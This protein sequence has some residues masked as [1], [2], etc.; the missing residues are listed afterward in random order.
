MKPEQAFQQALA[1][2]K[3]FTKESLLGG[4]AIAGK[5]VKISSIAPIDGGNRITFSYV[6][7]DG[8]AKH[9]ALDVMNGKDGQDGKDG[10]PGSKGKNGI[11]I[12]SMEKISTVGLVDTYRITFS[13]G[14]YFDYEVK[15]G[16][17]GI[18]GIQG[19]P[20]IQGKDG[21]PGQQGIQ[22][23]QGER[24]KDGYPFL[25]YR[26]YSDISEFNEND[27]P[28]IGLMF[29]VKSEIDGGF[30]VY[31]YTGDADEAYSYI[32]SLSSGEAIKGDKGD[33]GK[34]GEQGIPGKDGKDGTTYIPKIGSV[35]TI[36]YG[37]PATATVNVDEEKKEAV[38]DFSIPAGKDG[39]SVVEVDDRLSPMSENPVQNKVITDALREKGDTLFYDEDTSELHLKS[40]NTILSTVIIE[41]GSG[42]G[43]FKLAKPENISLQNAD[44][45][46]IIEWTDPPDLVIN[47]ATQ[48][49]WAGTLIVRK[50][51][52]APGSRTDGVVVLDSK[53][54]DAHKINGFTD[55]NLTNGVE[56]FYGV[57][58]YT[59]DSVYTYGATQSITPTAIYP[60]AP[61]N[62]S[63]LG[64]NEIIKVGFSLP[65]NAI[66]AKIAYSVQQPES[67]VEP[68][69]TVV[70][71]VSSPYT[72]VGVENDTEYYVTVYS[73]NTKGR[74]TAGNMF[75]VM[76]DQTYLFGFIIN[77]N[78]S[79]PDSTITYI[80]DNADFTP[81]HM[82][83]D[84]D[85]FE[86]GSWT[87]E[88]GAWFM[89][90]KP[91]MLNYDGTVAYYLDP[92]DYTKKLDGTPSDIAN[93]DFF[94]N[95]M[96]GI[97][98]VY[99]KI[100]DNGDNTANIYICNK[101][102]DD[103]FVCW[104][105]IDNNGN[106]IDYCYM[107]CYT[108]ATV[109]KVLRSLSGYAP[110]GS[111]SAYE[112]VKQAKANN[113]DTHTIWNNE[114]FSDRILINLLLMLIGK[115]TDTQTVF[116]AGNCDHST[117]L[118]TKS[119]TM[120]QKG[121]FWGSQ[122]NVSGVKVFGIEHYWGN[123]WRRILGWVN[124]VGTQ[125]IKMT[126]GKFD[127][128]TV[129]GYNLNGYNYVEIPNSTP[130]GE[131]NGSISKFIFLGNMGILPVI[132]NGSASTYYCD[133]L[134]FDNNHISVAIVG[135]CLTSGMQAGAFCFS[136]AHMD[137]LFWF[138]GASI[139]CKPLAK[140]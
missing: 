40:G 41:G 15:N 108:G 130:D 28:E 132:A 104:S 67:V 134:Y 63:V 5:N 96:A 35:D 83:Y 105:H 27:F 82:D 50:A 24:G 140:E 117:T 31:R 4:G 43:G 3:K 90:V 125:K 7:D 16:E 25:I 37:T 77:Q 57:F 112:E 131:N 74:M 38:F 88:N 2:S 21:V 91:C 120:N 13:N 115:S 113:K 66:S 118:A 42:G 9:S 56:Y 84:N 60:D 12:E 95:A 8:T 48:A 81:A 69:G 98:K 92:N 52:S 138:V 44:E 33:S 111:L 85:R 99:W 64:G 106:E 58:P 124:G 75:S 36:P 29:M 127:G 34:D 100:V 93:A 126:Y 71:E 79:D 70:S 26:E 18:Q 128:S 10:T 32:T 11:G 45:S 6:L 101:K 76:P 46:V 1:L 23:I 55:N 47:G 137:G 54:R 61:M 114:V 110:V 39:D 72:I 62:V 109:N 121:M 86:P 80:E 78:E 51:G 135:G 107:P 116:G 119:G 103:D 17:Q 20:G 19:I 133:G 65:N 102:L 89:D 73:A 122:D 97:P 129:D 94:G 87:V 30:P 14:D 139:S 68:Y 136:I 53:T 49:E 59:K 123:H 22:G